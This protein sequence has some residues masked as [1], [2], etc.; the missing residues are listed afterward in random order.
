MSLACITCVLPQ[1][2][3]KAARVSTPVPSGRRRRVA[4]LAAVAV[5]RPAPLP[6]PLPLPAEETNCRRRPSCPPRQRLAALL[7]LPRRLRGCVARAPQHPKLLPSTRESRPSSGRQH[8]RH[9]R[10]RDSR[11][12]APTLLLERRLLLAPRRLRQR[13]ARDELRQRLA[14]DETG[15]CP[16]RPS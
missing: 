1:A 10:R 9:H 2:A 16:R 5:A 3:E 12:C 6:L 7:L 11:R 8:G 4:H 13:L 15:T 14:R